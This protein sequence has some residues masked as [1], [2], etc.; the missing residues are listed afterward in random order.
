MSLIWLI[1]YT[2]KYQ[3]R[4][5]VS[6]IIVFQERKEPWSWRALELKTYGSKSLVSKKTPACSVEV[7]R[8]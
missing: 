7:L 1:G 5:V 8:L 3:Y 4:I 2:Y 6:F